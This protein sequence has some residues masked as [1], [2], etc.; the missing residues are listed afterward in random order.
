MKKL[1]MIT[2][3]LLLSVAQAK[4]ENHSQEYKLSVTENGFEPSSLKVKANAPLILKIT[5]KTDA[6][7]ARTVI[8]PSK[9]I[10]VD[11]PL[12]KETIIPVGS[13]AKGEIK[14]GCSMEMMVNAVM[15]AE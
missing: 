2:L 15:I 11:L 5:R 14:F 9:N 1:I 7:C 8:I 3:T 4:T 12:N 10:K 6:T 13:L